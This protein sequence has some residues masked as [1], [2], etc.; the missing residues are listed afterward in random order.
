MKNY[1]V[2]I[3]VAFMALVPVPFLFRA[4]G[5]SIGMSLVAFLGLMMGL[6]AALLYVHYRIQIDFRLRPRGSRRAP[7]KRELVKARF[8][9]HP[10]WQKADLIVEPDLPPS[11]FITRKVD[12]ILDKISSEGMVSLTQGERRI[13]EVARLKILR[14]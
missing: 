3:L 14:R 12:P 2:W 6:V 9:K 10:F 11:E 8:G 5:L 4:L 7:F 1:K 13:L